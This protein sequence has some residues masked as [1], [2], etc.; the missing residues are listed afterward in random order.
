MGG[1]AEAVEAL[2]DLGLTEY[3]ARCFVA[4]TQLSEGTAKEISQ[5]AEVPQSRVYDVADQLH[6]RGVVDVQASEPRRYNVVPLERALDRLQTEYTDT[7]ETARQRLQQLEARDTDDDGVWEVADQADVA[8]RLRQIVTG[9]SEEVYVVVADEQLLD[10]ALLEPLEQVA[11]D[12]RVYAEVPS[13]AA[14]EQL[15]E[16]VPSANVALTPLPLET[17]AVDEREPGRLL[18]VD[19]E[20]VLLTALCE[21]LVPGQVTETGLWSSEVGH[22][23]VLWL[24]PLLGARL[25]QLEFETA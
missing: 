23:L 18:L 12:V 15:H 5:I 10:C 9:A 1:N 8:A 6:Q 3:E 19:R 21:G 2:V 14:R 13:E 24:R 11:D 7:L 20:T 17:L 4:L 25:E 22:G 16:A